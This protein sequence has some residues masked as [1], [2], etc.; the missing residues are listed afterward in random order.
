MI[1]ILLI[2]AVTI[3]VTV[4]IYKRFYF[5]KVDNTLMFTGA[6]G[7]G[8]TLEM[9]NMST[10]LLKSVRRSVKKQNIKRSIHN[11]MHKDKLPMIEKPQIYS[12]IP[13][14]ISKNEMSLELKLEHLT[15]TE[16]I[17]YKSIT[18]ITELGKVVSRYENKNPNIAD[19]IDEFVSLY[20]QYTQGGY[21]LC[22]DQS[23][24]NAEVDIRRRLGTVINM[25]HFRRF[26]FIYWMQMRNITISE[27]IKTIEDA[28][29]EDSMRSKI[30]FF[31]G[32]PK[33]DTYAFSQRY[34][35]VPY[36]QV[37]RWTKMKTNK[38]MKIPKDRHMPKRVTTND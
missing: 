22:D 9:V 28:S 29:A 25:L 24:D 34:A 2:S 6:P 31:I 1:T 37:Q 18:V 33:Y 16:R 30:G 21:F 10:K 8:K 5:I 23:S 36:G 15:L 20:R 17:G 13:I 4:L 14:R 7:T 3:Y 32:K 12:N 11:V 35:S 19:N 38:I 26:W 27:D